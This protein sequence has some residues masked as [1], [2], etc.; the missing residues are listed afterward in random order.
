MQLSGLADAKPGCTSRLKRRSFHMTPEQ[1][2]FDDP[3]LKAAVRHAWSGE[4]APASLRRRVKAMLDEENVAHGGHVI[5]PAPSLWRQKFMALG[6]AAAA[7]IA[8]GAAI[9][10]IQQRQPSRDQ[11]ATSQPEPTET[12]APVAPVVPLP[13]NLGR[14][15]IATHD[16]CSR[17]HAADHHQFQ[18]A[19]RDNFKAIAQ[20]MK[21]V[22]RHPVVASP[23][24]HDWDFRGAAICPV[25][26]TNTA[27]LLFTR[28]GDF[29]SVFSLPASS[30]PG[31]PNHTICDAA[32]NGRL[33]A[34]FVEAGGFHCVVASSGRG[35]A[36]L[37]IQQVKALRDQLRDQAVAIREQRTRV[38]AR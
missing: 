2:R 31:S 1:S 20:N 36:T 5:R 25:G 3:A 23:M 9:F 21:T 26:S 14:Q 30:F 22:L 38:A 29:V 10:V 35:A 12:I 24:G 32:V 6:M 13:E 4:T 37:D 27:H 8:V 34:G 28:D 11:A 33:M 7:A 18:A 17:L 15:L 19:P 16:S